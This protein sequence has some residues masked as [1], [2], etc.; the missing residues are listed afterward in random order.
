[1][2]EM[3]LEQLAALQATLAKKVNIPDAAHDLQLAPGDAIFSLDVQYAGDTG[4]VAI[5]HA[6]WQG[7]AQGIYAVNEPVTEPYIP[8]YFAFREG[9]VLKSALLKAIDYAGFAPKLIIVDGHGTAHPRKFGVACWLGIELGLPTLGCAKETL[10]Q[11]SGELEEAV[12][13]TL[14]VIVEGETVGY[15]VRT[16]LGVKPVFVSP[17]HG[18]S[19]EASLRYILGLGGG[20]RVIEPLRRAD[21]ACR[22]YAKGEHGIRMTYLD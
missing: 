21:Q 19:L 16:A 1:M 20:Y 3:D 15:A 13:S 12:G 5:D 7:A 18:V 22:A 9:P 2:A 4:F 11:Y 6:Q 17:G 8:G 14:P 10:V